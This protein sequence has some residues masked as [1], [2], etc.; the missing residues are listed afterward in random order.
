M[1]T[2]GTFETILDFAISREEAAVAF[3][4]DLAAR[5]A[6]PSMK[7]VFERL[8]AEET[9]HRN[10]LQGI[11]TDPARVPSRGQVVNLQVADYLV[12]VEPTP[13]TP[14]QDLLVIAIKREKA[15]SRL[16]TD[17]AA[18]TDDAELG[19]LL[20]TLAAEEANH[21]LRFEQEYDDFVLL[22]N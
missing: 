3:Y 21:Q 14:Y 8:A 13:E 19:E 5:A 6:Q 22:E 4:T 7:A 9:G 12:A 18:A 16:Y 2:P 10:M 15:A 11:K 17:L 20:L 1:D